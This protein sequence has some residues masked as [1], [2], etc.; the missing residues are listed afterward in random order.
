MMHRVANLALGLFVV[1]SMCVAGQSPTDPSKA[2][3]DYFKAVGASD[4][5]LLQRSIQA[6]DEFKKQFVRVI[7]V[8]QRLQIL[9]TLL[10]K[11]Y[12]VADDKRH[13]ITQYLGT[14]ST[15]CKTREIKV[16]GDKAETVPAGPDEVPVYFVRVAGN[17]KLDL[18]R[19]QPAKTLALQTKSLQELYDRV[20]PLLNGLIEKIDTLNTKKFTYEDAWKMVAI[21]IQRQV[22]VVSKEPGEPGGT[23][24][25]ALP[26]R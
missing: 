3:Q 22:S 24:N 4:K 26:H 7:D 6:P 2:L 25:E 23:A 9:D 21:Q 14:V 11:K 18:E 10:V 15:R 1:G 20:I 17:W 19:G 13:D 5:E 12:G 8:A 16:N